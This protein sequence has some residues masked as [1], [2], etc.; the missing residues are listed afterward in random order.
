[1]EIDCQAAKLRFTE[2]RRVDILA[3]CRDFFFRYYSPIFSRSLSLFVH[4]I[5]HKETSSANVSSR[6]KQFPFRGYIMYANAECN[7]DTRGARGE[8]FCFLK[9]T[10][11]EKSAANFLFTFLYALIFE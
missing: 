6:L 8:I 7:R 3:T 4:N 1:M 10:M 5:A 9:K 2:N 11:G